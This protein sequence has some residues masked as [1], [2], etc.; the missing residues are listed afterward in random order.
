MPL[1]EVFFAGARANLLFLGK[2]LSFAFV[3][4][5]AGLFANAPK[6]WRC[7]YDARNADG[8]AECST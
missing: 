2:W 3:L 6:I 5:S 7:P 8:V 1:R 4:E